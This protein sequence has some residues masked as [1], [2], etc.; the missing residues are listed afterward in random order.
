MTGVVWWDFACAGGSGKGWEGVC[1][2]FVCHG[3]VGDVGGR[4]SDVDASRRM[5]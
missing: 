1:V 4:Q 3:D 2:V 5:F